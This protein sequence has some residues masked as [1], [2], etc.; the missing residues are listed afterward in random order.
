MSLLSSVLGTAGP[1]AGRKPTA[2]ALAYA[3]QLACV[4]IANLAGGLG[5]VSATV[6]S[7]APVVVA[8]ADELLTMLLKVFPALLHSQLCYC[9]LLV[10]LQKEEGDIPMGQVGASDVYKT[11]S[12]RADV[13]CQSHP[14]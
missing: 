12:N 11:L 10:Q 14:S 13:V 2:P 9:A 8:L 4:L 1:F 7:T 6:S 5:T 3:E